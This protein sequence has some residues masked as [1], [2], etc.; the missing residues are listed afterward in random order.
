MGNSKGSTPDERRLAERLLDIVNSSWMSQ[1]TYVAV[2]LGIADLL[3]QAPRSSSELAAS[4]DCHPHALHQLLRALCS[5]DICQERNDGTFEI[6]AMGRLLGSHSPY[7]VQSWTT[8]WGEYAWPI[9]GHLYDAVKTGAD[10]PERL[11]GMAAFEQLQKDTRAAHTFNEAMRELTG[12][13][14]AE[15]ARAYDFSGKRVADIGGGY[16]ELLAAVLETHPSASGILFDMAHAIGDARRDFMQ[17]GL[18]DRCEFL[19]GDFFESVPASADVYM[20]KN[21]IH[22][23]N[24]ERA[25]TILR[26]CRRAMGPSS[27]LLLLERTMPARMQPTPEHRGLARS[28]LNMRVMLGAQNRTEA[29]FAELLHAAGFGSIHSWPAGSGFTYL[30]AAPQPH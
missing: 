23:W 2:R 27:R 26:N 1:A 22:D 24:D 10:M 17:R 6:S 11:T 25:H 28:D 19:S 12:L 30:E 16:G 4:L 3:E 8:Y 21:V 29:E 13:M 9:W 14:T 20:L 15:A 18:A 7:S 5:L